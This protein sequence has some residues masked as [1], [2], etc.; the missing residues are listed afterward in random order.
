MRHQLAALYGVDPSL[1]SLE[2]KG[3][4]SG[5]R[6]AA[7]GRRLASL[8]LTVTILVPEAA[9]ASSSGSSS[10]TSPPAITAA[11]LLS[12]VHSV[13]ASVVSAA[14]GF[15]VTSLSAPALSEVVTEV[16][17]PKGHWCSGG[18]QTPCETGFYNPSEGNNTKKV[19]ASP[20]PSPSPSSSP[21]PSPSPPPSP[22]PSPSP[23]GVPL[24]RR[25]HGDA[26]RGHDEPRR[27]LL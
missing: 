12:T 20:T 1:I 6:L 18:E 9:D 23:S 5:R 24:V 11:S 17:C 16:I 7:H 10:A 15:S 13:S 4:T 8:V 27:L 3:A 2:Q 14:V 26:R 21:S 25:K 19:C 22:T